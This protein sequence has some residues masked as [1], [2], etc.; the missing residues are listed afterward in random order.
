V[1]QTPCRVFG[2]RTLLEWYGLV[3]FWRNLLPYILV[4]ITILIFFLTAQHPRGVPQTKSDRQFLHPLLHRKCWRL[5]SFVLLH[6]VSEGHL[7][8][9]STQLRPC[10]VY[11]VFR[12]TVCICVLLFIYVGDP[13]MVS[14]K[15]SCS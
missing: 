12:F 10:T 11:N 15:Q 13:G 4:V 3:M 14:R 8:L 5:V 6:S 1:V 2:Y 7:E 9:V